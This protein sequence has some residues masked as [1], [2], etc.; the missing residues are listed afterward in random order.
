M[1]F[2]TNLIVSRTQIMILSHFQNLHISFRLFLMYIWLNSFITYSR[3]DIWSETWFHL[4]TAPLS[5][6]GVTL[7]TAILIEIDDHFLWIILP[8]YLHLSYASLKHWT[9]SLCS[10]IFIL[11]LTI[12]LSS[13]GRKNYWF[14]LWYYYKLIETIYT[15]I[16]N[17]RSFRMITHCNVTSWPYIYKSRP[18]DYGKDPLTLSKF[19]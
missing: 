2:V 10:Y 12:T 11:D 9:I 17:I 6:G 13:G 16:D 14:F 19:L 4:T 1:S 3:D 18:G 8:K 15:M 7:C 5:I